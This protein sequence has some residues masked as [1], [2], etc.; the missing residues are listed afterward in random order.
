MLVA[1]LLLSM[2]V[3][4]VPA[5]F[6]TMNHPGDAMLPLAGRT[7]LAALG[8]AVLL[9]VVFR[10]VAMGI[11]LRAMRPAVALG[12]SAAFF[13]IVLSVLPA[14]QVKIADPEAA[15]A[16]FE[17]LRMLVVRFSDWRSILGEFAPLLALGAVLAYARWRT[18]SLWLPIGLHA[19]WRFAKGMLESLST[20]T[21]GQQSG[22]DS[23]LNG[24]LLQQGLVPLI[25]IIAAG[26]LAHHLTAEPEDER[27]VHF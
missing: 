19:G 20:S 1:G 10:G 22:T 26:V 23:A 21:A 5:G 2:G 16:G 25:A 13:A 6:F 8:T 12:M 17:L 7:L 15:G 14:G 24:S 4:L 11:F 9:E 18:A 27:A 3:A